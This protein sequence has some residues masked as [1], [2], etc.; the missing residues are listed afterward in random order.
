MDFIVAQ[1]PHGPLRDKRP[2]LGG[3]EIARQKV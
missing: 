3:E 2:A 1:T